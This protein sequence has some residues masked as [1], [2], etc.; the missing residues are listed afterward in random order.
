[1]T[2]KASLFFRLFVLPVLLLSMAGC[3]FQPMY[4]NRSG[5]GEVPIVGVAI[6]TFA[7]DRHMRQQLK[8]D[9][10][11]KLNPDGSIPASPK[12]RLHV[13]M[14]TIASPIGVARDGT[15]SRYNVSLKSS[16][17]LFT[18]AD[19]KR[20]TKGK[21]RQVSS[22]NNLANQYYSTYISEQ[23]AI[24]RGITELAELYRQRLSPYLAVNNNEN[25]P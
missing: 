1:M 22:Y 21:L 10:E 12:Y 6:E 13:S 9:L 23:D 5:S 2:S 16:Y 11:D 18:V 8:A 3:G 17:D 4:G 20:V 24:N 19:N 7:N 14:T 25:T 15:V